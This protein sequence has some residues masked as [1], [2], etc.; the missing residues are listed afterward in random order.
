VDAIN[1]NNAQVREQQGA[2]LLQGVCQIRFVEH[3]VQY[4]N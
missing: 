1:P 3:K 2:A 4:N